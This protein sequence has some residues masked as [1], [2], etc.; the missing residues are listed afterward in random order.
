MKNKIGSFGI[1]LLGLFFIYT[2]F[3]GEAEQKAANLQELKTNGIETEGVFNEEYNVSTLK[4]A[5]MEAEKTYD[6]TY[7]FIVD[8]VIYSGEL[9]GY[10]VVPR[11]A[12]VTV[13]YNSKNPNINSVDIDFEMSK[14]DD[15]GKFGFTFWLGFVI[16]AFGALILYLFI[17]NDDTKPEK[18]EF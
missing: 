10:K 16:A 2:S 15:E 3:N 8:E 13:T 17:K 18:V 4:I 7:R 5:G 6:L 12:Y 1:I 14:V 9:K 11:D